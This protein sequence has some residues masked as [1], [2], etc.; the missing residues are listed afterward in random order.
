MT[1]IVRLEPSDAILLQESG[2]HRLPVAAPVS[3]LELPLS[4][5]TK[6]IPPSDRQAGGVLHPK[7]HIAYHVCRRADGVWYLVTIK[8]DVQLGLPYS[9]D[10]DWLIALMS[11]VFSRPVVDGT[12]PDGSIS[13]LHRKVRGWSGGGR[14]YREGRHALE[15]YA[16][17]RLKVTEIPRGID[18]MHVLGLVQTGANEELRQVMSRSVSNE[19]E[20]RARL[21]SGRS[22]RRPS[23]VVPSQSDGV[24]AIVPASEHVTIAERTEF[25]GILN[26]G[27]YTERRR[28]VEEV[29]L[30][31]V[32]IEPMWVEQARQGLIG[33]L[34]LEVYLA[35]PSRVARD[36]YLVCLAECAKES[37]A[38][39]CFSLDWLR[40]AVG[41]TPEFRASNFLPSVKRALGELTDAGVLAETSTKKT[42]RRTYDFTLAPGR[43]LEIARLMNGRTILDPAD[44]AVKYL[45]LRRFGVAP[46]RALRM[47]REDPV[48]AYEILM[49]LL[50]DAGTR[51]EVKDPARWILAAHTKRFSLRGSP[52][53]EQWRRQRERAVVS[54]VAADRT[55]TRSAR[56]L[57][58][59]LPGA[60]E[61]NPEP[62]ELSQPR[63]PDGLTTDAAADAALARLM[64]PI[65]RS[66]TLSR[67]FPG[68]LL[69]GFGHR[70]DGTTLVVVTAV[71]MLIAHW[72]KPGVAAS[73][74]RIARE[75]TD[76]EITSLRIEMFDI[77]R[78]GGTD[79]RSEARGLKS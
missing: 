71:E 2:A 37:P 31:H 72:E 75:A 43:V 59:R 73:V 40:S 14:S 19:D 62:T 4:R 13:A 70:I 51:H 26:F 64:T 66:E 63:K 7:H 30:R 74:D 69:H 48:Q 61:P 67:L 57:V 20:P 16:G 46:D 38:P 52:D 36:L 25:V 78:H 42:G 29:F 32:R 55:F 41:G 8:G 6:Q 34:D 45:L 3:L 28:D 60:A 79:A 12:W 56:S 35:L 5:L 39:W 24:H 15:R 22:R 53:Y 17:V 54:G 10:R 58:P 50:F 77:V 33:W 11:I 1:G 76:G 18:P 65:A 68:L 44:T 9:D 21:V 27:Q 49:Y 23:G 47:L